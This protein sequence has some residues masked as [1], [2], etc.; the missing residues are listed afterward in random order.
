MS[1]A[2]RLALTLTAAVLGGWLAAILG[3]PLPWVLGSMAGVAAVG[4]VGQ[5]S[6]VFKRPTWSR[7]AAQLVIGCA[8]GLY[9]TPAVMAQV[10]RLAFWMA[11]GAA[12]ALLLSV[13]CARALQRLARVDGPTA[14]YAMAIGASSEM[15]LQATRAGA[16]GA[17]VASAHAMRIILVTCTVSL[18]AWST[19]VPSAVQSVD[20]PLLPLWVWL[21]LLLASVA[22]GWLVQRLRLPNPWLL[23]PLLVCGAAA[24][25]GLEGR[26]PDALLVASQVAIGWG[27]GQNISRDF[28]R[29]AP[30]ILA[31]AALM[32]FAM[33]AACT[34]FA[35]L[36]ASVTGLPLLTGFVGLAPGGMAEMAVIAK[37]FGLGA[38]V[39]LGFH[40]VRMFATIFLT[41]YLAAWM[42]R[43][44]WVRA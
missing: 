14:I 6:R 32:T 36:M 19:G 13:L 9:F 24:G 26:L 1:A 21:C 4:L 16:D 42:L 8:M 37:A 34:G 10:G 17:L 23:G 7:R 31:S 30:R 18:V 22:V 5:D 3:V 43:S 28:F 40:L 2:R 39:V 44:G 11:G 41:R 15:S 35:A 20:A 29:R 12:L 25:L 33:I 27:L 38:P